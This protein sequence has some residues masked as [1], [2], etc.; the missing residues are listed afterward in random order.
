MSTLSPKPF[1]YV[2]MFIMERHLPV[3][4]RAI[5]SVCTSNARFGFERFPTGQR[6]TPFLNCCS[7]IFRMN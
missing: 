5:C 4:K 3:Q 6:R 2:P 1:H 7:Y